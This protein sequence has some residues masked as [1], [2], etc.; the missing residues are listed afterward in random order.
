MRRLTLLLTVLLHAAVFFPIPSAAQ[1]ITGTI[2]GNID[3]ATGAIVPNAQ[4]V[5][6]NLDTGITYRT[7]G[8]DAGMYVLP[9]LP[10]GNYEVTIE[11]TGFKKFV[12][13]GLA[14]R[15]DQRL[16]VD[17]RL[18]LGSVAE[19]VTV[20]GGA[21]LVKTDQSAIGGSF[22]PSQFEVLPIGRSVVSMMKLVPGIQ[23]NLQGIVVGNVNGSR[24]TRTDFKIDGM[25]AMNTNNGLVTTYPVVELM[26][27]LVIQTANYSAESGRGASQVNMTTRAG[28]NRLRGTLF[29]Y[30][31]NDA[32][33]ANSYMS[34]TYGLRKPV[35]R[36]N[37]FGGTIGGPV[38]LPKIYNGRN[39]TFFSFGYEGIRSPNSSL[40]VS[41][42][43]TAA[44][45]SGD[46]TGQS[47]IHDPAT[48][49][50]QGNGFART[51]F[52]GNKVPESRF[53]PVA[54]KMMEIAYPLPTLAGLAN[55][56]VNAGTGRVTRDNFNVRGDHNFNEK[57]RLT[58][59]FIDTSA[60][61][62]IALTFPGPAG[63]AGRAF[64]RNNNIYT[65]V[66]S[67]DHVYVV[68]PDLINNLHFGYHRMYTPKTGPGTGEDW[69]GKVGLKN[70]SVDK[71]PQVSITGLTTF[72]G[73][74]YAI[75]TPA[76]NFLL[77]DSITWIKGRHSIKGGGEFR[78]LR[79]AAWTAGASSGNFTFNTLPTLDPQ[80]Q[81]LGVG[82]AGYLLGIPSNTSVAAIPAKPFGMRWN[83][84]AGY[85]QDDYRITSKL[86][87]N[88]GVRWDA[89]TPRKEIGD[90]QSNF[91]LGTLQLDYPG[92]NGY[93]KTI[94]DANWKNW[95]PRIG[96]AYSPFGGNRTVLRG[97]YG[98]FFASSNTEGLGETA[99]T[100]GSWSRSYSYFS[101]DNGITFPFTLR[102]GPPPIN[103]S[104]PFVLTAQSGVSWLSRKYPDDYMQ[105]WNLNIQRELM[106]GTMLE[107]GYV[108]SKGTHLHMG[109]QLN[110]VPLER[111]GPGDAQSRRPYPTR[112]SISAPYTPMGNSSYHSLQVRFERRFARSLALQG[113]YTWS[114][115]ID[116]SSGFDSARTNGVTSV[117]DNFNLR[118]ERSL[119]GFDKTHNLSYAIVYDLPVG[120]NRRFLD[121]GGVLNA[122]LGGWNASVLSTV[123]SGAP[124]IL[125]T[126]TNLTGSLG[127]GSRPNRL[128]NGQLTGEDRGLNRWFDASAY[129]SPAP[130]AFGNTS[131]TEPS[132]REPGQFSFDFLLAKEFRVTETKRFEVRAEFFNAA[133]HFNPGAPNATIGHPAVATITAGNAGRTIQL[134]AKFHY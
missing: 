114:K 60:R 57:S 49:R 110:Q 44:M 66:L 12:R 32:L 58:G 69:A 43:P 18:E 24:D 101:P 2:A 63:M 3:D 30:F 35:V 102:A 79:S 87:L 67:T 109:Y 51:A 97:G 72:G 93:P 94:Y 92:Q 14:L 38:F 25:P 15:A 106:P 47:T 59:R 128:R 68:R 75:K 103:M 130:F 90:R 26:E 112:G 28:T 125:G 80:T 73:A 48:T 64:P 132:L 96:F 10:L 120:K 33:N 54:M 104:E 131:R 21:P 100:T 122:A 133:N 123:L 36:Q 81:R 56:Y 91:N 99:F 8:T 45:R 70:V 27:E 52:P 11:V 6:R 86:V 116:D 84:L 117:Q 40:F 134:S 20:S 127:G 85:L 119:S 23:S 46:F 62:L 71:F 118:A 89:T 105:Q 17:V 50:P 55:N 124:L 7:I 129:A 126:F 111:L 1:N 19:S 31:Q 121:R 41:S 108:G 39:R 65:R 82:F 37:L 76:S 42:V 5:A 34:N 95:Q 78:K 98:I 61:T 74:D 13:T 88:L 83:Y 53:D 107:V 22:T 29:H 77:S 113:A 16:R 4:V 115:S 9:L